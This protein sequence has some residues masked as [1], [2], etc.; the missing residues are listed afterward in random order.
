MYKSCFSLNDT[1]IFK[2]NKRNRYH[3]Y[4][5]RTTVVQQD[6][7]NRTDKTR[8]N[9]KK[10]GDTMSKNILNKRNKKRLVT[11]PVLY[12]TT[13]LL[14]ALC[15]V[16]LAQS[17]KPTP[18]IQLIKTGPIYGH[19][20]EDITYTYRVSNTE[21]MPLSDVT[22]TDDFCGPVSY[23][24]GDKNKNGKLDQSETWTFTCTYTP[25]FTFPDPLTNTATAYGIWGDQTAQDTDQY[26]LYPFILRKNVLLYWEGENIDYTDPDTQFTIRMTRC[27]KTLDT[28]Y[29]SEATPKNLWLSQ[30]T[31]H[32]TEVDVPQGFLSAYETITFTTGETYPDFSQLNIITFD[33]SVQKTG[34][35]TCYP[36][37]Q[38]TYHYTVQNSGP[39][40]ITPL[41][42]DDRCGTPVYTGG[43]S[44]SDGRIDPSETWTYEATDIINAEPGSIIIN[45]VTVTDAEGANRASEQWWLGGDI[46]LSNNVANWSVTVIS[47]PNEPEEPQEPEEHQDT[48]DSQEQQ[49]TNGSEVPQDSN[50]SEEPQHTNESEEPQDSNESQEPA[51]PEEPVRTTITSRYAHNDHYGNI[52]PH[53]NANGPYNALYNEEIEFNGTGSIDPDGFIIH[54][55][56]SFGD[57]D[58]AVGKTVTHHYVHGGIYQVILTV[59]DNLGVSDTDVTNATIVIPNRPPANP[60]IAGPVNGTKNTNYSYAFKSSDE[61]HND[62]TY[63][64]DWG[65]GTTYE[66]GFLP[67]GQYFSLIHRW[68]SSGEYVIKVV[69]SDGALT[70]SSEKHVTIQETLIADNIAIVALAFLAIIALLAAM[71]A[72]KKKKDDK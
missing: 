52:A 15:F 55:G 61:D 7:N 6:L 39:A 25:S 16:P 12:T 29:I 27:E 66:T 34:P 64:I 13:F 31:Y 9:K 28:F 24:C 54:Y 70:A 59:I 20:G 43:D 57:G 23:V 40:N 11:K 18:G 22:V 32:F 21:N 69:A 60:L 65:D 49:D 71:L 37:D 63:R 53:A 17:C 26:T 5:D 10:D 56:W 33:L 2:K 62:I 41:L 45:T 36:N 38:I 67:S 44:D 58:T 3:L 68:D 46:N 14:I 48:N 8:D 30:G 4:R 50:E 35:E 72:S 42:L 47:Q 19:A 51:P 1:P